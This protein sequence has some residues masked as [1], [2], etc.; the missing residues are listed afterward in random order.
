[1]KKK[2]NNKRIDLSREIIITTIIVTDCDSQ[3]IEKILKEINKVLSGNYQN[4]EILIVDNNSRD[5]TVS[6]IRALHRQIPHIKI[7]RLSKATSTDIAF[8]AG[9]DNCIGDYAVL[10]DSKVV[11]PTVI[12]YLINLL[13]EK[14]DIVI[15]K[16]I[17]RAIAKWS[18]SGLFLSTIEK[19]STHGFSYEPIHLLGV[20]R[21]A[22]NSITRIRRKS[23]NLSYIS[24]AIGF[25]RVIMEYK[26]LKGSRQVRVPNF[27]EILLLVTDIVISNS[28]KPIRILAAVGMTISMVFLIYVIFV[29]I[30]A[31][32][33]K[34][35]FAPKG[36]VTL[37]SVIGGM[38]F[39][40]FSLLTL[41]SEYIIRILNES[42]NEP[43]YFI[44]D[45]MDKSIININ[46][47]KL[48]V[49]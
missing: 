46:R 48:N 36:W 26:P 24:Y 16:S 8:T 29:A 1:M 5:D 42:R 13:L 27:F 10:L 39:L 3:V 12:P 43:L 40:L 21:K 7:I 2:K 20:N 45:E 47:D 49:V 6:E 18:F 41:I 17:E 15:A 31:V 14:Y 11:S 9:L 25:R 19:L 37:A 23:R 38:F 32:F 30:S 4:Y 22:I 33:F 44:A 35:Y 28:F 34:T